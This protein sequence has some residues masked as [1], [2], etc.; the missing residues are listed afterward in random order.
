MAGATIKGAL[1]SF[2]P[3]AI[4]GVPIPNVVVFQI[5]PETITHTWSEAAP[6]KPPANQQTP[7]L[8]DPLAASGMPGETFSFTLA[9]DANEDIAASDSNP[10]GAGLAQLSGS[11]SRISAL[12][13]LQYPNT[14]NSAG[15]LGAVSSAI[16]AAGLGG[17]SSG[18]QLVP[19][20]EVPLVLF[21]WG[22]E[23][24][25]PVRIAA[26]TITEKLYD[27]ALNP[28]HAD[29]QVTLRVLTPDDLTSIQ[30]DMKD[31]AK[32]AYNYTLGLRQTG[33]VANVGSAA[34][35]IIGMLPSLF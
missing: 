27:S 28:V 15:L 30:S 17:G 4:G 1:I 24:I 32:A 22:P 25:L 31:V 5:N 23:R 19:Q 2:L 35:S 6:P 7:E 16:S 20:S 3:T 14:P 26:L 21:V 9:L 33:A 12:E 29:A 11:Y 8:T 13:M 34:A 18:A 10:V